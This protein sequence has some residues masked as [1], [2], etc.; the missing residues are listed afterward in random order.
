MHKIVIPDYAFRL[1]K[2]RSRGGTVRRILTRRSAL[3]VID[4]QNAFVAE[5]GA[6]QIPNARDIVD[7][8]NSIAG[9]LREQGGKVCW[10]QTSFKDEAERW[11]YWFRERLQPDASRTMIEN[12][13]PGNS[14][15]E[16]FHQLAVD[17]SDIRCV[18]T[19]FSPFIGDASDLD[20]V[21]RR[22]AVDTVIVVGAVSNTCCETT[23]RDAMMLNYRTIFVSDANAARTDDEHNATLGNMIQTFAEVASADEVI[24]SLYAGD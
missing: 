6:L 19:R 11:S 13:T 4:M 8:I 24:R 7:P 22:H 20:R 18:K 16:L 10:I 12:L 5:N 9:A 23:A 17:Q 1:L 3:L 14:G 21:L 2:E 15:Y